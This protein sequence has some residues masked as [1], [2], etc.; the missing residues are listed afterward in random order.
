MRGLKIELQKDDGHKKTSQLKKIK[1]ANSKS[2]Q[3]PRRSGVPIL[4]PDWSSRGWRRA[5]PTNQRAPLVRALSTF[6]NP[7]GS[8]ALGF[9]LRGIFV[10][11]RFN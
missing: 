10:V 9:C 3:P 8:R 1:N 4:T 7:T 5:S 11:C 6:V 2:E